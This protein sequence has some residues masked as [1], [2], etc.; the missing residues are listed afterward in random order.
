MG[1][2][3]GGEGKN[4]KRQAKKNLVYICI[5]KSDFLPWTF[6]NGDFYR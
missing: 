2:R 4:G 6:L 3:I 1:A 5:V